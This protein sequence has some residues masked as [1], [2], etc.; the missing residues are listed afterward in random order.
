MIM[1]ITQS[2]PKNPELS[3]DILFRRDWNP[4]NTTL[5]KGLEMFWILKVSW[6]LQPIHETY[7]QST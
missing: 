6:D 5:G 3:W 7:I 1:L 2:Y 4:E